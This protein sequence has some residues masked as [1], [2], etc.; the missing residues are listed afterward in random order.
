[1]LKQQKTTNLTP[2]TNY[3]TKGTINLLAPDENMISQDEK[4]NKTSV[5]ADQTSSKALMD[6]SLINLISL[7]DELAS[8]SACENMKE[9]LVEILQ[10]FGLASLKDDITE[11]KEM[12]NDLQ[13]LKQL[14][15]DIDEIKTS[16]S[17]TVE[18]CNKAMSMA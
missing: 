13:E 9:S 2:I 18:T 14:K 10:G 1:M 15:N 17:F 3:T 8:A 12:K 7:Q 6:N 11:I 4:K 16:L 5:D